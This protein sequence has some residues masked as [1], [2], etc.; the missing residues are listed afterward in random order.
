MMGLMLMRANYT[1][2]EGYRG[3]LEASAGLVPARARSEEWHSELNNLA[4]DM[5]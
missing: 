4:G 2:G 1:K 3:N 5:I